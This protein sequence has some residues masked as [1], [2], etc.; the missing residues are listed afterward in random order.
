[1]PGDDAHNLDII[2]RKAKRRG[3]RS[4]KESRTTHRFVNRDSLHMSTFYQAVGRGRPRQGEVIRDI[5]SPFGADRDSSDD[6]R[7]AAALLFSTRIPRALQAVTRITTEMIE[8]L[9]L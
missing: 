4:T 3:R 8:G 9:R 7:D 6:A 5:T 1:M 2:F